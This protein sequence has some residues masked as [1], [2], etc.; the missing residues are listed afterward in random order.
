M[1]QHALD[2]RAHDVTTCPKFRRSVEDLLV[3]FR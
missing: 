2:C 1:T 3:G